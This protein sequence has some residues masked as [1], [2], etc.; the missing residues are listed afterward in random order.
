MNDA[1]VLD[2]DGNPITPDV[3][4][5]AYG[6]R[7]F[8]MA[9]HRRGRLSW[10]RPARRAVITWDRWKVPESLRKRLK[11][12]PYAISVDRAFPEVVAACAKRSSTWISHDIE[13]LYIA[14]HE[15]GH[16]HSVEAWDAGGALVGGLYGLAI[17]S[18]FCGESMFHCADDAAKACVVHLVGILRE[19][20]FVVLDCQQQSPHMQRFGAYEISDEDYALLLERCAEERRFP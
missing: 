16:G 18:C 6:Q 19:R 3:V 11:S 5:H 9:D 2:A 4:L 15:Q 20:G 12:Q 8:P 7:C 14:L 13:R 1:V 17:G 10:Y